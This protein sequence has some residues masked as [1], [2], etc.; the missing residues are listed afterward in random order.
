MAQADNTIEK[1]NDS[2]FSGNELTIIQNS[3]NPQE[4]LET[5]EKI[6]ILEGIPDDKKQD[7][8]LIYNII[9]K[10]LLVDIKH[11]HL[12]DV[13]MFPIARRIYEDMDYT[14]YNASEYVANYFNCD[15]KELYEKFEASGSKDAARDTA[16][17]ISKYIVEK[18]K[19]KAITLQ[20]L[21]DGLIAKNKDS[22]N[23]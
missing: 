16:A 4:I 11:S 10:F 9:A 19:S 18:F 14:K 20:S 7:L 12:D 8:A 23:E 1:T 21:V 3:E 13:L 22:N 6:G 15:P 5:Y 2:I 17:V